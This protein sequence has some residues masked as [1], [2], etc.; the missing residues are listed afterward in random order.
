MKPMKVYVRGYKGA[1]FGSSFIKR[2]TF[3]S[4]SHVS[5]V[6]HMHSAP[7]EIESI[8]GKGLIEHAPYT[9]EEKVFDEWFVPLTYEQIIDTHILAMSLLGAKY[10]WQGI[11]GFLRRKKTHS[12]DKFFCS[13]LV[14][15]VLLKAGYPL[16]RREPYRETPSSVCESLRLLG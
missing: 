5:L 8:Q 16:S 13:E 3:G 12:K 10:D 14:A 6:F 2:F 11:W 1:G 7:Q 15:Y 9:P 4:Y